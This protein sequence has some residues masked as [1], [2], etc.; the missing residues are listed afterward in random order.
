MKLYCKVENSTIFKY[1]QTREQF[2]VGVNSPES[3]CVAKGYYLV[4]DTPPSYDTATQRRSSEYV[5][6]TNAKQV[7]K[8]YTVT[9]IPQ[10]ELDEQAQREL[11]NEAKKGLTDTAVLVPTD[12][13]DTLDA[14][15][16]SELIKYRNDCINV[17]DAAHTTKP[18]AHHKVKHA[19]KKYK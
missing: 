9:D 11:E 7:N 8:V 17:L 12:V 2:G 16:Q 4:I 14:E 15:T 10:A 5:V 6:D 18:D 19:V 3:A 1:N 13:N